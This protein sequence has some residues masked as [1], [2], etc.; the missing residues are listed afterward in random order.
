MWVEKER[1]CWRS[2]LATPLKDWAR[3][4]EIRDFSSIFVKRSSLER[5]ELWSVHIKN[6]EI[7]LRKRAKAK[8][9][10][11]RTPWGRGVQNAVQTEHAASVG[12]EGFIKNETAWIKTSQLLWKEE[13][14]A[15]TNSSKATFQ[16]VKNRCKAAASPATPTWIIQKIRRRVSLY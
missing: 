1:I 7:R 8:R 3:T 9:S 6:V 5:D 2:S 11:N 14:T 13:L 15:S 10:W 4:P 16:E 12:K